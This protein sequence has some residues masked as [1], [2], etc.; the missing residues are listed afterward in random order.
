MSQKVGCGG[1]SILGFM[2]E[3]GRPGG[4]SPSLSIHFEN[5]SNTG[6]ETVIKKDKALS[7]LA[8]KVDTLW[9][10]KTLLKTFTVEEAELKKGIKEEM[11]KLGFAASATKKDGS[12][13]P[14]D[15]L[16]TADCVAQLV[17]GHTAAKLN[18]VKLLESGVSIVVLE[19]C[20]DK[21]KPTVS[22]RLDPIKEV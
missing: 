10:L 13:V 22:L 11:K 9:E 3:D 8:K 18:K 4:V 19:K 15:K 2:A 12:K 7:S 6:R 1:L 16:E 21:G 14:G 5:V 17:G 20:T